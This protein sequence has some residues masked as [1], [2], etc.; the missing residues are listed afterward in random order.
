MGRGASDWQ[1]EGTK[2]DIFMIPLQYRELFGIDE[3]EIEG[4][5]G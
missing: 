2:E 4:R 5:C 3:G 1:V